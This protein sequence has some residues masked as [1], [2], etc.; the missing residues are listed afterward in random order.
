LQKRTRWQGVQSSGHRLG[1]ISYLGQIEST[2]VLL[3]KTL[4]A[5]TPFIPKTKWIK[6]NFA[7][8]FHWSDVSLP[9]P[10]R[11]SIL[12]P[13]ICVGFVETWNKNRTCHNEHCRCD[14][15]WK[16][17]RPGRFSNCSEWVIKPL[18]F[19]WS[20][21]PHHGGEIDELSVVIIEYVPYF[22]VAWCLMAKQFM[23][24]P[25]SK[26]LFTIRMSLLSFRRVRLRNNGQ[27]FLISIFSEISMRRAWVCEKSRM[28]PTIREC[29]DF[30]FD[31]PNSMNE[32]A[33]GLGFQKILDKCLIIGA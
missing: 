31:G 5:T 4:I 17:L 14:L 12:K 16:N 2:H 25:F 28:L 20:L 29:F 26:A 3:N 13:P 33:C 10:S 24:F 21:K 30:T 19:T 9:R 7:S 23:T 27:I 22:L 1:V 15:H 6:D 32:F 8:R 11:P 18:A